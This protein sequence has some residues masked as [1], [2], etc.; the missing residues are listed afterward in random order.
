[1]NEEYLIILKQQSQNS[2]SLNDYIQLLEYAL[3]N[4]RKRYKTKDTRYIYYEEHH[5]LPKSLFPE[6][7]N[8]KDNK[9]LLLP[10]EHYTAH[11]LLID[12]FPGQKMA[13]AFWRM[14]CCTKGKRIIT[15]EDYALARKLNSEYVKD[16]KQYVCTDADRVERSLRMKKAWREGKIIHTKEAHNKAIQN[17]KLNNHYIRTEEQNKATSE[18]LKGKIFVNNGLKN[19]R[20]NS[21]ELEEYLNE[22][23]FKGKK[24]LSEE[25][26]RKI[27]L[28]SKGHKAWNKG[29]PGTFLGKHHTEETKSKMHK[30]KKK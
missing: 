6:Y 11:K 19:K 30:P 10:Q 9:V 5:I 29:L 13:H 23:W 26:K 4:N 24:P 27:G 8:N 16:V 2:E 1:M 25:H 12:I 22:G 14:T 21:N 17:R 18:K 15:S 28:K 3:N 20:I 7:V